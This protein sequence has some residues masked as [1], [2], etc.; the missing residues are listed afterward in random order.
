MDDMKMEDGQMKIDKEQLY[1]E[2]QTLQEE[3][4]AVRRELH[5]HP[6]LG[7]DLVYT[8]A[9]VKDKLLS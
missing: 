8:K 4:V 9:L 7:F 6:E 5:Q 2:A 3:L 1:K